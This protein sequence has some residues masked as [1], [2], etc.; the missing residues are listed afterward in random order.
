MLVNDDNKKQSSF[1]AVREAANFS[2]RLVD[3]NGKERKANEETKVTFSVS[4]GEGEV[5]IG[6]TT[7]HAHQSTTVTKTLSTTDSRVNVRITAKSPTTVSV[8]AT[9]SQSGI[10]LSPTDTVTA[11]FTSY[12]QVTGITGYTNATLLN[13]DDN[14]FELV[15]SNG[16]VYE[17]SYN[18][19]N[20]RQNNSPVD[21]ATF[22]RLLER[23]AT[24]AVGKDADGNIYFNVVDVDVAIPTNVAIKALIADGETTIDDDAIEA[25]GGAKPTNAD[26]VTIDY[27]GTDAL[28]VDLANTK[29]LTIKAPK[30]SAITISGAVAQDLVIDAD[31][32]HVDYTAGSIARDVIINGVKDNSFVLANGVTVGGDI[33][34][35]DTTGARIVNNSAGAINVV[36]NNNQPVAIENNDGTLNVT[37]KSKEATLDINGDNVEVVAAPGTTVKDSKGNDVEVT[38]KTGTT[39]KLTLSTTEA[40]EGDIITVTLEDADLNV[41]ATVADSVDILLGNGTLRLTETGTD[42][43][44]FVNTFEAAE[45]V[46]VKYNDA[47]DANGEPVT[48]KK[49]LTVV[50]AEEVDLGAPVFVSNTINF[51]LDTELDVTEITGKEF[52]ELLN[53]QLRN[54][55]RTTDGTLVSYDK[56]NGYAITGALIDGKWVTTETVLE[57]LTLEETKEATDISFEDFDKI[58]KERFAKDP[59]NGEF[60]GPNYDKVTAKI[61]DNK[62][63]VTFGTDFLKWTAIHTYSSNNYNITAHL[64]LE[65]LA[66]K[67]STRGLA[68]TATGTSDFKITL[69]GKSGGTFEDSVT[70]V[71]SEITAD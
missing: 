1:T 9:S 54:V 36:I 16:N 4:A 10:T 43:G 7:L 21:I 12:A 66:K 70:V 45:T 37:V 41:S 44:V 23:G 47:K 6:G 33:I 32:A 27:K 34:V 5:S 67:L 64:D 11:T 28:T 18:E 55:G 50:K 20:I 26:D 25:I 56:N 35:N 42:T 31:E 3:Q 68:V 15:A 46:D 51:K 71:L 22:E 29:N 65:D 57:D 14:T 30:T 61:V 52:L 58:L 19:N 17:Y 49:T 24:V 8:Y 62:L 13:K 60:D 53:Y 40:V 63:V 39:G 48:I 2:Y 38:K 69:Q 59:K